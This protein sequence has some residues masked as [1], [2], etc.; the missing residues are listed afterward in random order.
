MPGRG[1]ST[2]TKYL[3]VPRKWR[4]MGGL[5]KFTQHVIAP[6]SEFLFEKGKEN[7]EKKPDWFSDKY[8]GNGILTEATAFATR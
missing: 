6:I 2:T 3:W 5:F 7:G 4:E 1:H 8:N